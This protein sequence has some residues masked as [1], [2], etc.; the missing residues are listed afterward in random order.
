[1]KNRLSNGYDVEISELMEQ[2]GCYWKRYYLDELGLADWNK[3]VDR[4]LSEFHGQKRDL[5]FMELLR[6][7]EKR[8]NVLSAGCGVGNFL[9]SFM[10]LTGI[11][12]DLYGVDIS[13]DAVRLAERKSRLATN[14]KNFR[15]DFQAGSVQDLPFKNNFFD[16][17]HSQDVLEH[18]P[19]PEKAVAEM[20]RVTRK[21][22]WIFVHVPD[23]RLPYEPHYKISVFPNNRERLRKLLEFKKRPTKFL[24]ELNFINP[25]K[26]EGMFRKNGRKM[27]IVRLYKKSLS[28]K[29]K[30]AEKLFRVLGLKYDLLVH[31]EE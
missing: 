7:P 17:V 24:E 13:F 28:L 9:M 3:R 21:G 2:E 5:N 25:A 23:Y 18:L 6:V 19:D 30:L 31:I 29:R 12:A 8:I 20:V 27:S 22:G 10:E 16:I 4:R 14:D 26:V 15:S 11:E 1:M